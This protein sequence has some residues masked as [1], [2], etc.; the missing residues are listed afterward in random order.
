MSAL[1]ALAAARAAGVA[2]ILDGDG[3]ILESETGAPP[4]DVVARLR[5]AK[6]ELML[7]LAAE[8]LAPAQRGE[9][10]PARSSSMG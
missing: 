2:L 5:A 8:T 6:P 7:L 9:R 1:E 3:I 10:R 4:P